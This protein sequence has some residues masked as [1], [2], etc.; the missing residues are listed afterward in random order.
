[1]ADLTPFADALENL[2]AAFAAAARDRLALI[3]L[4]AA[5]DVAPDEA[6]AQ[7]ALVGALLRREAAD[8]D[9][10]APPAERVRRS[11]AEAAAAAG[12]RER[13]A[14]EAEIQRLAGAI[15]AT[16]DA[17]LQRSTALAGWL[18]GRTAPELAA[19]FTGYVDG[20]HALHALGATPTDAEI[21]TATEA[22]TGALERLERAAGAPPR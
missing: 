19:A 7:Q 16:W 13:L 18:Q 11:V 14:G 20:L 21:A 2:Q 6:A 15:D 9:E 22:F 1:M 4:V 8:A 12:A 10:D 17:A 5:A 3:R